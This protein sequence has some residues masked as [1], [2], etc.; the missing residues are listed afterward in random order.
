MKGY[1]FFRYTVWKRRCCRSQ[2]RRS[3]EWKL[4]KWPVWSFFLAHTEVQHWS[5]GLQSWILP[6]MWWISEMFWVN[7]R[8]SW[9]SNFKTEV[10]VRYGFYLIHC[11][12][13]FLHPFL[14]ELKDFCYSLLEKDPFHL[15]STLVHLAAAMELGHSNELYLMACNLVK[16][17][18]QK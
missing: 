11:P 14:T 7:I 9:G 15:K 13:S 2:V 17:Y 5:I 10:R 4:Q 12:P 6:S 18:P 8:V 3:W 1:F 16:D